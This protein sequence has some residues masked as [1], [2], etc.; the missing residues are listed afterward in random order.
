MNKQIKNWFNI[1]FW[2]SLLSIMLWAGYVWEIKGAKNIAL[3]IVWIQIVFSPFLLLPEAQKV[4]TKGILRQKF[5]L[6]FDLLIMGFLVWHGAIVTGV[7]YIFRAI[8]MYVA[9]ELK[10]KERENKGNY[11]PVW[12]YSGND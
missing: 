4:M 1:I 8:F 9:H 5:Y 3:C 10:N 11:G 12:D 2:T 7:F 6:F